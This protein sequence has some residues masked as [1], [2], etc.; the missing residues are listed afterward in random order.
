VSEKRPYRNHS[1][2]F[3]AEA[4][5]MVVEKKARRTEVARNL[6]ISVSLLDTWISNSKG[7]AK[8]GTKSKSSDSDRIRALERE[9]EQARMERDI[10]KKAVAFFAKEKP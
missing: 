5:R 1:A 10:L 6:G 7:K 3:K 9:L 2:E 4:V 8:S